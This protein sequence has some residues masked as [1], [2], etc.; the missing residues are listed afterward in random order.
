MGLK[1]TF[2]QADGVEK[3]FD[4]VAVG[5]SLMEFGRSNGVAGIL[6]DCGGSCACATCHIYIDAQW[7]T[8]VGLPDAVELMTLDMVS[9]V[10]RSNSRLSCQI[11]AR[12]EMDGLRVTVAPNV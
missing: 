12:Q 3:V 11:R 10:Y 2:V 1:L 5:E 8:V 7:Q 4:D 6:G 9:D